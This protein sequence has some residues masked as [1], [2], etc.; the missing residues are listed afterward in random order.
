MTREMLDAPLVSDA[1]RVVVVDDHQM[2][3]DSVARVLERA[4]D[5]EVVAIASTCAEAVAIVLE[6]RPDV[7]VVDFQLPDGDGATLA[8]RIREVS[9]NTQIVILTGLNDHRVAVAA[10][11]AGC[12]ALL[13]KDQTIHHLLSAGH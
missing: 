7:A 8:A 13:T 10:I 6:L 12:A 1:A 5:I 9:P 2:F 11:E 3:A 4:P